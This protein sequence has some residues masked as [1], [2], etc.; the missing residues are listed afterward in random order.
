MTKIEPK[1]GHVLLEQERDINKAVFSESDAKKDLAYGTVEEIT[2]GYLDQNGAPSKLMVGDR[3][4]FN[5]RSLTPLIVDGKLKGMLHERDIK[6]LA[7][8]KDNV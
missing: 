5:P 1:M 7:N 2:E 6:A 8:K 3:I 4:V